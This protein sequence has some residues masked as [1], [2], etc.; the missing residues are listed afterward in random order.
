MAE[1]RGTQIKLLPRVNT[2]D[3]SDVIVKQK[4]LPNNS[5]T[6]GISVDDLM[7]YAKQQL[8]I[9]QIEQ[10]ILD[11]K[12]RSIKNVGY[13]G[14]TQP[15]QAMSGDIW[16]QTNASS[17]YG[18]DL[19][20]SFPIQVYVYENNA[21][22]STTQ[23]WEP[24]DNDLIT[25]TN[26]NIAFV[27]NDGWSPNNQSLSTTDNTTINRNAQGQLQV[28]DGGITLAKIATD[29]ITAIKNNI[30]T[31]LNNQN[32]PIGAVWSTT[33]ANDTPTI[34][35]TW[36]R[37]PD[38]DIGNIILTLTGDYNYLERTKKGYLHLNGQELSR[39][40]YA[41]LFTALSHMNNNAGVMVYNPTSQKNDISVINSGDGS[42]TFGLPLLEDNDVLQINKQLVNI[43]FPVVAEAPAIKGG[44]GSFYTYN[45]QTFADGCVTKVQYDGDK[46]GPQYLETRTDGTKVEYGIDSSQSSS[47]YTNNNVLHVKGYTTQAFIYS[48][49]GELVE[50]KFVRTA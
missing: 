48:G 31:E 18:S 26:I 27:W 33:N 13:C 50:H 19:P 17:P 42:T 40:T 16:Y 9:S 25:N 45:N 29:T 12:V 38:I 5:Q 6:Q 20:T 14:A 4:T 7:N 43:G 23:N 37:I 30:K 21:W 39:T 15:S 28:I 3:G 11:L 8:S 35:G 46:N 47:I 36:Q 24:N 44:F 41:S 1:P 22:S 32:F 34:P 10:D 49:V 2:L